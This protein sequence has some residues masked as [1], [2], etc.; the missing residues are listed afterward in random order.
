MAVTE[1][2]ALARRAYW[3]VQ[4]LSVALVALRFFKVVGFHGKIGL[5]TNAV[6][7]AL[8]VRTG[9]TDARRR[10]CQDV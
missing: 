9:T 7:D 1:S 5:A 10:L 4:A 6:A 3:A 2:V 8:K